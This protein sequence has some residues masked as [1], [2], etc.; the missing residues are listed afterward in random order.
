MKDVLTEIGETWNSYIPATLTAGSQ[1]ECLKPMEPRVQSLVQ[2]ALIVLPMALLLSACVENN[3][4]TPTTANR[5][6]PALE[7]ASKASPELLSKLASGR[8]ALAVGAYSEGHDAYL[9][10]VRIS[11]GDPRAVIGL[12]ESHLALGQAEQ[13]VQ[14]LRPMQAKPQVVSA[15]RL[16]QAKGIAALRL[17]KPDE[18]RKLLERSVD[19]DP[20]HWRAWIALGRVH[21]EAGRK[22]DATAAFLMAEKAAPGTA[23][24][25][26][27]LGMAYLR[28]EKTD[29]AI[30][31]FQRALQISPGHRIAQAN[32]RIVKAMKGDFRGAMAGV[33][34]AD[35]PNVFNNIGYVAILNGYHDL[36]DKYLR[37]A[38]ELSPTYH[39]IAVA[40]LERVPD[41][42]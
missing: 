3:M 13:A 5:D 37:R 32:L 20:S 40:N 28:L 12:P 9:A 22:S 34:P 25:H 39:Q 41:R 17:K 18:A 16:D 1:K 19:A 30:T 10:A 29:A 27:D 31:H 23:S 38:I 26:N 6:A 24:A 14:L 15:A 8:N 21:L 11:A 7:T 42:P 36:A 35:S 33:E 2:R 4:N